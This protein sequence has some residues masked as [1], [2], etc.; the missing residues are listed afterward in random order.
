MLPCITVYD[1]VSLCITLCHYVT[2]SLCVTVCLA[3]C[4]S[5]CCPSLH[6]LLIYLLPPGRSDVHIQHQHHAPRQ[7]DNTPGP[8]AG[9]GAQR[10]HLRAGPPLWPGGTYSR[11]RFQLPGLVP[12]LGRWH[13]QVL[14]VCLDTTPNPHLILCLDTTPIHRCALCTFLPETALLSAGTN[15]RNSCASTGAFSRHS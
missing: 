7:M 4:H 6:S 11:G 10:Y 5:V 12:H 8:L 1:F 14:I 2:V 3:M 9:T 15:P 13:L